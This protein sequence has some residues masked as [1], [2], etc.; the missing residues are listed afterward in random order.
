MIPIT[1]GLIT[2]WTWIIFVLYWVVAALRRKKTKR[3]ET[4]VQ[5][6][7]YILLILAAAMLLSS[8]GVRPAVLMTRLYPD[9]LEVRWAGAFLVLAGTLLAFWARYHL[10][11]NWSGTVTLKEGHELVRSGPYRTIR[12][13]IYTGILV[14][15]LGTVMQVGQLRAL[16]AFVLVWLSLYIKASREES[17]LT[18]EFGANFDAVRRST[19]GERFGKNYCAVVFV[20]VGAA[21][22]SFACSV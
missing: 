5:R 22:F 17:F 21:D 20:S 10:G 16:L 2:K 8:S 15:I 12:H 3:S 13:P 6:M 4:A 9:S 11:S 7:G 18:A 1:P 14:S 19:V